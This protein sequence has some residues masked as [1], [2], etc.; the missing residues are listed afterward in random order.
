MADLN[1]NLKQSLN[2]KMVQKTALVGR[3]K[4]AQA[5]HMPESE[6]AKILS[7]IEKD[8][9]IR[10]LFLTR[11]TDTN[12]RIVSY[13]RFGRASLSAQFYDN[14]DINV[15]GGSAESPE[16]LLDR[17]RHL[18]GAIQKIGQDKFE[19]FFLY[20]EEG[21]SIEDI[22][23]QCGM[24]HAQVLELQD[25]VLEMSVNSEFYF[26]SS[27]D[28]SMSVKPTLV[29]RIIK[30]DDGTY[31]MSFYSPHLARGRYEVNLPELKK[32]WKQKQLGKEDIA[33][34]RKFVNLLDLCNIKQGAF[35]SAIDYLL[36]AQKEYFDTQDISKMAPLSLRQVARIL[37]FAPSTISRVMATKSVLL[38][39]GHEVLLLH[40][41][42][43]KRKVVLNILEKM[44]VEQTGSV[45]DSLFA[46]RIAES[47][48]IK[49]SRRTITTCR[50][51]IQKRS[52]SH[53]V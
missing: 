42:P 49:V 26:P 29:G 31:A 45:T 44:L 53:S 39:W 33:K 2:P 27:I 28:G 51:Q 32:W 10:E 6:W 3:V 48:G 36:T 41:M 12:S 40:L 14:Q 20:R 4:M 35:I 22:S 18:L 46:R 34:L 38:P 24:T 19:K 30:N 52:K 23:Q 17:K 1:I 16:T 9:L 15:V 8:P 13:R 47:F 43:G 21:L 25:F 50:H 5:I 7:D 37:R 11:S